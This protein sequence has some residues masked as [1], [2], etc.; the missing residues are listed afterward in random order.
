MVAIPEVL[1]SCGRRRV[2]SVMA[3]YIQVH[4]E[5]SKQL[6]VQ[7]DD[8]Y[9]SLTC[10]C[11]EQLH[12]RMDRQESNALYTGDL[13]SLVDISYDAAAKLRSVATSENTA[14]HFLCL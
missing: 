4:L 7:T 6:Q 1:R 8:S 2:S 10:Q 3:F 14:V 5:S 9:R 13:Q 11:P 12:G